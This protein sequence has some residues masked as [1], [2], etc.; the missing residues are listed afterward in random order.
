M[1]WQQQ[2]I[3][4]LRPTGG[5]DLDVHAGHPWPSP[6]LPCLDAC[7]QPDI[8]ATRAAFADNPGW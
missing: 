8:C 6:V 4:M 7:L 1:G 3:S 5:A 2:V